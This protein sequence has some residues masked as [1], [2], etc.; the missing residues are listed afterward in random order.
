M[1]MQA[2]QPKVAN[3]LV[4]T[5][6]AGK[7]VN[8][9]WDMVWRAKEDGKLVCGYE[10]SSINPFLEAADIVWVHGE[11]YSAMLAARHQEGPAQQAA[12][13]RGYMKELR[14][15]A[16][17]HLGCAVSNQRNRNDADNG[18][19]DIADDDDI[20]ARL[21]PPDMIISAYAYCS[22]GQQWDEMTSR[23]FGK[24]IPIFNVSIPWIWAIVLQGRTS[25]HA[26]RGDARSD[27]R[28]TAVGGLTG[29]LALQEQSN[30]IASDGH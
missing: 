6:M 11:A 1:N 20:A 28:A 26:C 12:Q 21:P 4:A 9:Y 17:T 16:R 2:V 3:K 15:Y 7:L 18:F 19:T 30:E 22:T 5:R 27:R 13:D 29:E 10:G 23:L 24:K 25:Q 14:S 8:E